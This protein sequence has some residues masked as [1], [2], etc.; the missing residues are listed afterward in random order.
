MEDRMKGQW[1]IAFQRTPQEPDEYG[2]LPGLFPTWQ[3]ARYYLEGYF[4]AKWPYKILEWAGEGGFG[5]D[6]PTCVRSQAR[7]HEPERD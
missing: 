1:V 2:V 6:E 7:W 5:P 4:A 3:A